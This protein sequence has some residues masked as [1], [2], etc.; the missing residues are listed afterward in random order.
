[1]SAITARRSE[2][3]RPIEMSELLTLKRRESATLLME[4]GDNSNHILASNK[5]NGVRE[6]AH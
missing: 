2:G 1:M 3:A 6:S 5:V 4:D